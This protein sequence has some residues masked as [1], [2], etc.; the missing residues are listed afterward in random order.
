MTY[1]EVVAYYGTAYRVS[2]DGG[3]SK[4]APYNW[5]K[6]GYIPIATQQLIQIKTRGKLV[7]SL[8]HLGGADVK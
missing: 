4:G 8:E 7:A 2:K 6:Q 3:F 1:D 5:K